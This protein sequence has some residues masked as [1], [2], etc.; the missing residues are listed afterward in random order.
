VSSPRLDEIARESGFDRQVQ[1]GGDYAH[2]VFT[3]VRAGAQGPLHVYIEG[4]GT[5]YIARYKVAADPTPRHPL[6]LHLM[7]LDAAP[8]VYLGRP[9]YFGLSND[10]SCT[11]RDWTLDRFSPR[12]VDSMARVIEQLRAGRETDAIELY[13][14]SGGGALAVLLAARL[15]GVQRIVTIGG[16]LDVDAWTT[17]HGYTPLEGSLNPVNAGPLPTTLLQQHSVG[18]RDR[19]VPPGLVETAA[20]RLGAPGAIVLTG[21]THARGWERA[22]PAILAGDGV[23]V[24]MPASAELVAQPERELSVTHRVEARYRLVVEEAGEAVCKGR[25]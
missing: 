19:V 14:H 1:H 18:D 12:I 21:L 15:G 5:P 9:C 11:P 3:R 20:R 25:R 2:V 4:D 8:S 23:A 24:P 7:A 16:N 22:W 17:Y 13:G 6:M 10:P